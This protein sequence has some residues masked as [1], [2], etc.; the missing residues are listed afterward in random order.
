MLRAR[1]RVS[2]AIGATM[3]ALLVLAAVAGPALA[4]DTPPTPLPEALSGPDANSLFT[5]TSSYGL[6][7]QSFSAPPI[8][9]QWACGREVAPAVWYRARFAISDPLIMELHVDGPVPWPPDHDQYLQ[10]MTSWFC[11]AG[12]T[13]LVLAFLAQARAQPEGA[14]YEDAS[15]RLFSDYMVDPTPVQH[16]IAWAKKTSD[17]TILPTATPFNEFTA[18]PIPTAPP[19][20]AT[21]TA[22]P[23][24]G[25]S[26]TPLPEP[27]VP[28]GGGE[29]DSDGPGRFVTS[30][31]AP[32][33]LSADP[34]ILLQS[35]GLALLI[36][37][38]MPFP[39]QLFNSTYETHAGYIRR[40]FRLDT[41][42]RAMGPLSGFWESLI[43][44]VL[45]VLL[46]GVV[47]ALLDPT[48]S[49][50]ASG[51][52]TILGLALGILLTGLL[53]SAPS[54]INSLRTGERF[55]MRVLPATLLVGLA[56]VVV[57]RLTGFLPGYVYGVIL[58]FVFARELS[59]VEQGRANA[60]AALAMLAVALV[61]WLLLGL[62]ANAGLGLFGVVLST[63]CATLL[64]ACL[65]GVVFG[66]L[67]FRFL[68]GEPLYATNRL[69]W[70]VLLFVGAFCFLHILINPASGYM[71]STATT[72]LFTMVALLVGFGVLSVAFWAYFRNKP[73]EV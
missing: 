39:A 26:A 53:V 60:L 32:T 43:G 31:A 35:F 15:C 12:T 24:P 19:P 44:I 27:T 51:L 41:L 18:P 68:P 2:L 70:A 55:K 20:L 50:S 62:L 57:S 10:Q 56:C 21:P 6:S 45:F 1:T 34:L 63:L 66:L 67:P 72:P 4:D 22:S 30:V 58:G 73:A 8:G 47:Y 71:G 9:T 52:A 14:V 11:D 61:S 37:L 49:L 28:T 40:F 38:L 42:Q 48:L 46:S 54:L 16:V 3:V 23:T 13:D 5:T 59:R 17:V 65:E 64:V 25:I 69:I 36:V 29:A 33:A 7:C